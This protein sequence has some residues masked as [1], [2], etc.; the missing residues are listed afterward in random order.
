MGLTFSEGRRDLTHAQICLSK[1]TLLLGDVFALVLAAL[2]AAVLAQI[3]G[4][5]RGEQWLVSQDLQRYEAWLGVVILGLVVF[6]VR[7]RHYSDRKPYWSEL[8]EVLW[9][10]LLLSVLDL[11]LIGI[12]R[13]N[14]SRL[15]W[16]LVWSLTALF[17]PLVRGMFR[18]AM[19]RMRLW[20]RPTLVIGN[21]LNAHETAEALRSEPVLGF[22][23]LDFVDVD[24]ALQNDGQVLKK[25]GELPGMQFVLAL[26]PGQSWMQGAILRKLVHCGA[27]DVSVVPAIR[28]VP[29]LGTNIS[30]FFSHEV[31]MLKL[32][33]NLRYWPS[34]LIK[35]IF[36]LVAAL[37][38]LVLLALPFVF[39]AWMIRRDGG[40]AIFAHK[41]VGQ[42]GREFAC[43][44]F[45]TMHVNAEEQLRLLL[46]RDPVVREEWEREFKLRN[47]PRIT[48]IGEFL[49]QT[50]LDE[51]PQ[52]IN[53]I[54]GEMSLVGP[55]PVIQAELAY[56]GE[57]VDYFLLVR[58]G[59]TGLWQVSGRNDVDYHTRVY[60]DTWYVKNWS[61]W[62]DVS[63]LF[64]TIKVVF[65][66]KGAY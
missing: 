18:S 62:Y 17:L 61:L 28:G 26:E 38:L 50:S 46:A 11:A 51:L 10:L 7:Y 30:Y 9:V 23:V 60:L 2:L 32:R 58:P 66:R 40:P 3:W 6:W 65:Q 41:R 64:K 31:A 57:D 34:R 8:G 20:Q 4:G 27:E 47:D 36:D 42:F 15:W 52:L 16:A 56:Y 14:S 55:R 24:H 29:L 59:V 25:W 13:W 19:R 45:R 1:A 49:R 48:S 33:N 43:F 39:M 53:V 44:K 37:V 21:G 5:Q 35:R 54:R 12:S 63:I 22:D